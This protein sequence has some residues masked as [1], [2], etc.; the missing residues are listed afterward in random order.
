M[1]RWGPA[2]ALGML[3]AGC[4]GPLRPADL[5]AGVGR[6]TKAEALERLGPPVERVVRDGEE[7]WVYTGDYAFGFGSPY[8]VDPLDPTIAGGGGVPVGQDVRETA[9]SSPLR[10]ER[11]FLLHFDAD[12][13]LR[14]WEQT[15]R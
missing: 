14:R 8:Q 11:R 15:R 1:R 4:T 3:L 10:L 6:W 5:D 7:T 2:L 13:V 12:G 9:P